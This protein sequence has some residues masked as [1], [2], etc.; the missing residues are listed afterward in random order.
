MSNKYKLFF[1]DS[2]ELIKIKTYSHILHSGNTVYYTISKFYSV[3]EIY[4]S[5]SIEEIKTF[6]KNVKNNKRTEIN[7][8]NILSITHENSPKAIDQDLLD[9]KTLDKED[10]QEV[11]YL[12]FINDNITSYKDIDIT[13][14]DDTDITDNMFTESNWLA[15]DISYELHNKY[16]KTL[17][18][19]EVN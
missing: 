17:Q 8:N 10:I 6:L 2:F 7:E 15:S 3:A 19:I 4:F 13:K 16:S 1:Q 18:L 12:L 5:F 9:Y 11:A 14:Y